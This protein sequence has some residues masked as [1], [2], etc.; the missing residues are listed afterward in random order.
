MA[1][2]RVRV[3][4]A[5]LLLAPGRAAAQDVTQAALKAAFIYNFAKFTVWPTDAAPADAPLIMC[6]RGDAAIVVALERAITGRLI[7]GRSMIVSSEEAAAAP[8][9][10]HILYVSGVTAAEAA[11]LVAGLRDVPTLTISDVEGFTKTGGIAQL[12][13]DQ[14]RLSFSIHAASAARAHLTISS[15]LLALAKTR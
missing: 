10:C 8:R 7:G 9:A 6:V 11:R 2:L 13:Y 5:V 14:G 4:I 12:F 1:F 3:A 15:R